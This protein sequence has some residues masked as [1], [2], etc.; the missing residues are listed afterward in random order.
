[1]GGAPAMREGTHDPGD[2]DRVDSIWNS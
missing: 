1:L 2:P